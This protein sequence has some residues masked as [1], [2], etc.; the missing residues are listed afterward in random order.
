MIVRVID[1]YTARVEEDVPDV[2][3][4]VRTPTRLF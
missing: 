3:S 2:K 4:Y 1:A